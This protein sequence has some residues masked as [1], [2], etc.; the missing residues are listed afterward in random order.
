MVA[1]LAFST[2]LPPCIVADAELVSKLDSRYVR[3]GDSFVFK[4]IA[5]VPA[6][7]TVPEI[8]AGSK[9]FGVVSFA[10]HA[11]PNGQAG[12][13]VFEPRF[14]RLA[15]DVH[16][17]ALADPHLEDEFATGASRNAPDIGVVPVLGIAVGA[18]NVLHRGK[19]IVVPAG[20][21]LRVVLG[22]DLALKRCVDPPASDF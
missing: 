11:G 21:P 18:Y 14:V 6:S 2:H 10:Q 1:L 16:V 5:K 19:E 15:G 12:R 22:D 13:I 7:N 9:G 17:P 8:P 20:T 3:S 4:I